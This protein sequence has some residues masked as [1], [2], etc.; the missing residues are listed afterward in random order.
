VV[1]VRRRGGRGGTVSGRVGRAPGGAG[2]LS[3][4]GRGAVAG[5]IGRSGVPDIQR[6]RMIA[7]LVEVGREHGAARVTVAHVVARSGVSRRTFY[8]MFEDRDACFMAALELAID[9][10]A[11]RVLPAFEAAGGGR[12]AV[13]TGTGVPGAPG[14]R[15]GAEVAARWLE[16]VRA[17]LAALLEFLDDEPGLGGLCV[18]DTLSACPAAL[19]RRAEIIRA[20]VDTVDAGRKE[21]KAGLAPTR[22]TAEGVVGGVLAVLYSRFAEQDPKPMLRLLN[23]LMAM[24]MLPYLGPAAAA[25]EAARPAPRARPRSQRPVS[26]PLEGLDMRLTY[27]T[28]RVLAAIASHANA[29]NRRVAEAAGVQDQGQISKLLVRLQRLGL[30]ENT[31]SG[32]TRGEPNAWTLTARGREVEHAIREQAGPAGA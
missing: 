25:K 15:A 1:V 2:S 24:I 31:G 17:G 14:V 4:G 9:R 6:A 13:G 20:F 12:S 27:R 3:G 8:E 22:L 26:N 7:A 19:R 30:I 18:V 16:Q 21:A 23:P 5:E 29:S 32:A 10:G 28:V 11:G